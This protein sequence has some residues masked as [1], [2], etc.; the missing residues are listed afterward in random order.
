MN[1]L[2]RYLTRLGRSKHFAAKN[3]QYACASSGILA[4]IVFLI[5]LASAGFIP[6]LSPNLT[7]EQTTKHYQD[8]L[9]GVRVAVIFMMLCAM[10]YLPFTAAISGQIKRIP[11]LHSSVHSLQLAAG[12]VGSV[13]FL[14]PPMI[15]AVIGYRLE[16]DPEITQALSD[17]FF[18]IVMLPWPSFLV[19]ELAFAY[20]VLIDD[21]EQPIFPKYIAL[22]NI[23]AP[24]LFLPATAMHFTKTGPVAW[25]GGISF[26]MPAFVFGG[27]MI[28]DSLCLMRCVA[29][30]S[31]VEREMEMS[32]ISVEEI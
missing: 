12:A 32:G 15:L 7:A 4:L 14:I 19:Q 28:I 17:L 24:I 11:N 13:A 3:F 25:N 23:V 16:R 31:R 9:A 22:V 18:I 27:L 1:T 2:D 20:A 21:R 5:A 29:L 26:W 10:L 30:E 8:H 6:P